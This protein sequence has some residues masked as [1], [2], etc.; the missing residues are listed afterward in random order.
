MIYS[1]SARVGGPVEEAR[2]RRPPPRALLAVGERRLLIPAG[3]GTVGR[4]RDC[5]IVLDDVG[6]SRRHAEIRPSVD[7]WTITDLGSTNGLLLN[8]QDVRGRMPL[9]PKDRIQLGSTEIV[10]DLG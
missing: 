3:G 10:F 5:D 7:G 9:H 6:I 8:G 4:S 2:A 1:T